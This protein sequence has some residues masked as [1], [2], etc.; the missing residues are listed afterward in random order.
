M[1]KHSMLTALSAELFGTPRVYFVEARLDLVVYRESGTTYDCAFQ[2]G[3]NERE[4]N[5]ASILSAYKQIRRMIL[6]ELTYQRQGRH[7]LRAEKGFDELPYPSG[8][9]NFIWT[10]PG[11]NAWRKAEGPRLVWKA[12]EVA[13]RSNAGAPLDYL[14]YFIVELD[15]RRPDPLDM[16]AIVSGNH[17]TVEGDSEARSNTDPAYG[18]TSRVSRKRYPKDVVW[19]LVP[20]DFVNS[21]AGRSE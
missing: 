12:I 8:Y 5:H 14:P 17:L 1:N 13:L 15:L 6:V 7:A 18:F 19:E 3:W 16:L 10:Q 4:S 2:F 11:L 20:F 21:G 9:E